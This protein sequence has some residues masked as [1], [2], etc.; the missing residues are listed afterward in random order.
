MIEEI[1]EEFD[2]GT[3]SKVMHLTKWSWVGIGVPT[4]E[5]L[6]NKARELLQELLDNTESQTISTGG[7]EAYR[8]GEVI[9]LRFVLEEYFV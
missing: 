9:G 4:P 8:H 5:A 3:V 1:L 7:L 6:K 2:F